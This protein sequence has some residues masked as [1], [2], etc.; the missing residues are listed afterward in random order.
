MADG[1]THELHGLL[2]S[3]AALLV[4]VVAIYLKKIGY[5]D[6]TGFV[7]GVVFGAWYLSPDLD[8]W[9][10]RPMKKWGPLKYFWAPYARLHKHRGWS[11]S[12]I[13]G[14]GVRI[15]YLAIPIAAVW[16]IWEFRG[17]D[18]WLLWL[19]GGIYMGNWVHLIGDRHWP[20]T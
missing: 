3:A 16:S 7:F 6:T 12:W 5:V 18:L 19:C 11:H 14:P 13:V 10:T 4:C 9:N 2:V 1:K 8:M 17:A 15:L 20:W